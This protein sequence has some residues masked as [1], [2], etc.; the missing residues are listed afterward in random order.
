MR[1]DPRDDAV[2]W[3][4][5]GRMMAWTLALALICVGAAVWWMVAQGVAMRLHFVIAMALGITLSLLLGAG[6]MGLV[7]VSAR[8]G[9]DDRVDDLSG[10]AEPGAAGGEPEPPAR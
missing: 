8:T 3:H 9:I 5:F 6:L 4:R 1:P 10:N 2:H 7:F